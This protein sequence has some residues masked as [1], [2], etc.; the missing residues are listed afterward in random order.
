MNFEL[1]KEDNI[2]IAGGSGMVGS[3]IKRQFI[4]LGYKENDVRGKI[5]TPTRKE[6]DLLNF[7]ELDNWFKKNK[8]SIVIIAAAKVGGIIANYENPYDFVFQNLKIQTNLIEI[9]WKNNIRKL[10][11]LGSSCIYPKFSDQPI[12]E[13]SLLTDVLEPTNEYYAIAKIAG[14]KLCQSLMIQH[15]F[16]SICIMPTN[17]Y[18]P[19]DNYHHINSHVIPSLIRKFYDAKNKNSDYVTCWGS[20]E[21]LREFLYVDDLAK[22]CIFLLQKWNPVHDL[23]PEELR[24]HSKCLVNVGT[25]DEISIKELAQKIA[26]VCQY[27]GLIKWDTQKPD[28]TPRKKVDTTKINKLGWRPKTNLDEGLK[29]TLEYYKKEIRDRKVRLN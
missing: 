1:K 26:E 7:N 3:A 25:E 12:K 13:E 22:A 10:L 23:S 18:G 24:D 4:K 11:F 27:K 9:A 29:N 15:Q 16:N 5:L 14:I 2:F 17:L 6:L 8:P 28:G 21:P 19:G 20:G